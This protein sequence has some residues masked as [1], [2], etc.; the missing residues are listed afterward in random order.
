MLRIS[1]STIFAGLLI[2][3]IGTFY[4]ATIRSG[5]D[6]GD[7]FSMY[8]AHAKNIAEGRPYAETGYLY[9]PDDPIAPTAYPPGY[10]LFLSMIYRGWGLNLNAMK[11]ANI[12]LFLLSLAV[13]FAIARRALG[14]RAALIVLPI[15]GLNP[16]FWEFKDQILSET[17]FV[18]LTYAGLFFVS[19]ARQPHQP[20]WRQ[21]LQALLGG[22]MMLLACKTRSIGFVLPAIVLVTDLLRFRRQLW[23]TGLCLLPVV[24]FLAVWPDPFQ[25]EANYLHYLRP[26]DL[27]W[28][29][30]NAEQYTKELRNLW[31]NDY[32]GIIMRALFLSMNGLALAGYAVRIRR[33]IT[34]YELFAACYS[35]AVLLWP[36][37]QGI[38]FFL[39]VLPLYILYAV[40]GLNWLIEIGRVGS[41]PALPLLLAVILVSY[42]GRYT[43]VEYGPIR[44]GVEQPN[45]VALL[46]YV[47]HQTPP[48]AVC[49]FYKP[50]LLALFTGRRASTCH[51]A[52]DEALLAYFDRIGV[53]YAIAT[54][55]FWRDQGTLK[56]FIERHPNRFERVYVNPEFAVYRL[57]KHADAP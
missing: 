33:G 3:A 42:A 39:P 22:V 40:A 11:A 21:G 44:Q 35:L 56:P 36:S 50:R 27:R 45:T 2:A 29:L 5:H 20:R 51:D 6:V 13:I 31:R 37:Y 23:L 32:S 12:A 7:D 38:R 4:L 24:V 34:Y 18:L 53:D 25:H 57:E 19:R 14:P 8:I 55:G 43:K 47:K 26:V 28:T 15:I 16:T 49:I 30:M 17:L 52:P 46:E 10:P 48:D 9:N 41:K 1:R 54:E